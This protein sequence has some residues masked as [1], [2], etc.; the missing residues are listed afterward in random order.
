[1]ATLPIE[2]SSAGGRSP[3]TGPGT[4]DGL[5]IRQTVGWLICSGANGAV[6]RTVHQV[7]LVEQVLLSSMWVEGDRQPLTGLTLANAR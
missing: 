5:C 6:K 2:L 1:M 7:P 4:L 3:R